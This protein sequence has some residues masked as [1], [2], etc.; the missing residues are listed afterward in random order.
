[1]TCYSPAKRSTFFCDTVSL[2]STDQVFLEFFVTLLACIIRRL[3]AERL[4]HVLEVFATL[5]SPSSF[6]L[7]TV[8]GVVVLSRL[9]RVSRVYA[10]VEAHEGQRLMWRV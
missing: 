4:R 2:R 1:M 8:T 7:R 5:P 6:R 10:T 3:W 9:A